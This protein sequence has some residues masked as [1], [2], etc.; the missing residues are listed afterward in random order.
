VLTIF[1][2][3][4]VAGLQAADAQALRKEV[5][6]LGRL[7]QP[8]AVHEAEHFAPDSEIRAML[9]DALPYR[10]KPTRVFAWLGLPM[11][12]VVEHKV[13]GVV[14]VHGGGGTAYKEWVRKWNNEGFAAI[15]IAVEGQTDE[16]A[17]DGKT[18]KRH[19]W[20]GPARLG[21]YADAAE[22]LAEQWMYHA[23]AD[24]VLANSLL[25]SLPQVDADKVGLMGISWGGIIASTVMGIDTR[26][27][28]VIPTY[29]CGQLD[30]AENQ[31]QRA[32]GNH[33]LYREVWNP[34]LRLANAK[35]PA[36]WLT[37][38]HD[39]HFP[40]DVQSA[41]YR[42][43]LGPRQVAVLPEMGH[44]HPAGWNPPDSYA[45][46]KAVVTTGKPWARQTQIVV[47]DHEAR[48]AFECARPIASAVLF[49]T[50]DTG[51]TGRR[52][53]QQSP[54]KLE[55][56]GGRVHVSAQLPDGTTAVFFN[57]AAGDVTASSDYTE[58]K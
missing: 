29:G 43:A 17:A 7:T 41:S 36:L 48:A 54:A 24:T 22:P 14:L 1:I 44:S 18:W 20:P 49:H 40:L 9:F 3:A 4:P 13:P 35:M 5:L 38:L 39:A 25:R 45:F 2:L 8:P 57:L 26:W 27:A 56:S 34:T 46:A 58:I 32:L 42:V 37:W 53:W 28:F 23:V 47:K 51:Y 15:S 52:A 55:V 21:I 31:Y 50:N 30:K 10:G 16:H 11:K 6:A 12:A 33:S 19:A